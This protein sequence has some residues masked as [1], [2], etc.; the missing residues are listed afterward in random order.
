MDW[1]KPAGV[2]AL[3]LLGILAA[4]FGM[5]PVKRPAPLPPSAAAAPKLDLEQAREGEPPT[6]EIGDFPQLD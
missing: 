1:I 4:L 6:N 3:A 5:E 2:A